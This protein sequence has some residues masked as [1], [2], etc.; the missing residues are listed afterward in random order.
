[1]GAGP[2][3]G[4]A[5]NR[6]VSPLIIQP[7]AGRLRSASGDLDVAM[8]VAR[9]NRLSRTSRVPATIRI[10]SGRLRSQAAARATLRYCG[11]CRTEIANGPP[12]NRGSLAPPGKVPP[13]VR[14]DARGGLRRPPPGHPVSLVRESIAGRGS[15]TLIGIGG[16]E[17]YL[18]SVAPRGIE[19]KAIG[20]RC[21]LAKAVTGVVASST[22]CLGHRHHPAL[23]GP[24]Q[25]KLEPDLI[26]VPP[27]D[28][29]PRCR[30]LAPRLSPR[31]G[32]GGA[33]RCAHP[34]A[35]GR[36]TGRARTQ[37]RCVDW[38]ARAGAEKNREYRIPGSRLL[39]E[40]MAGGQV[41]P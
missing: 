39:P 13:L 24:I 29:H 21:S 19:Q 27:P 15:G 25:E 1:M 8:T 41:D 7:A 28:K 35:S 11:Q 18:A 33:A 26:A 22:T 9:L 30:E 16:E 5:S 20:T 34:A 6:S 31:G 40:G 23:A 14:P 4:R 10:A 32:N 37:S 17:G 36:W 12:V 38:R 2:R 3:D